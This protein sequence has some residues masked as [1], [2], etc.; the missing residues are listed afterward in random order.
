[1]LNLTPCD[2]PGQETMQS[3][4]L[5][6]YSRF[7]RRFFLLFIAMAAAGCGDD[8]PAPEEIYLPPS[9]PLLIALT[10]DEY[11]WHIRYAGRDQR[12]HTA[13][14]ITGLTEIYLPEETKI[15]LQLHSRDYIYTFAVDELDLNQVAVPDME[16]TLNFETGKT[17]T[18]AL[19]SQQLCGFS[20]ESL[21]RRIFVEPRPSFTRRLERVRRLNA[22]RHDSNAEDL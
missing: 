15:H 21:K 9:V 19:R 7:M 11:Y 18:F 3:I 14:D 17:D 4:L 12:L 20:H 22:T 6:L 13:D 16:F 5:F 10:G 2:S 8:G 1:M